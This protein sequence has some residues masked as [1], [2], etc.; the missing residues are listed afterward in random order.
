MSDVVL[1]DRPAAHV[2]RLLINRPDKRNAIDFDVRQAMRDNLEALARDGE[3]RA[4]V[5]GGVAG[6]F[7][8]GGDLPSMAG[9]DE[10]GARERM[11]HIH[12]LCR[13]IARA[14]FPVVSAVEGVAAGGAVGLALLGD[15]IVIEDDA[16][17]LFP[18]LSLGL[19]PDWGQLLTLPQR[20][21]LGPARRL[22]TSGRPIGGVEAFEIGL[23][24]EV[25]PKGAG[26][27]AAVREAARLATLPVD[28]FVRTR[29]RLNGPSDALDKE[30][31][32]EED[33]Q[34]VCL[35]G[36]EF[37]EGF[38]AF[39]QKRPPAFTGIAHHG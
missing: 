20:V 26:M 24:D 10:A 9:L 1:L 28:A 21:G 32:R 16:R 12:G 3:V 4:L 19:A 2:A 17:V 30:L 23:A 36:A 18:F 6:I 25:T 33:D 38:A 27:A 15:Y 37:A 7:S 35:T 34:A 29:A 31:Q 8:A 14:P 22:L 39:A 13:M 11:R 5:L